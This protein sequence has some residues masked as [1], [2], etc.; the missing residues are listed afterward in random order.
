MRPRLVIIEDDPPLR[1]YLRTTLAAAGYD[2]FEAEN[3]Q[4]GL[5]EAA[6][7]R[8][9]AILLDLGLPDIDGLTVLE[10]LRDWSTAPV[11]VI[12][13]R[14]QEETKVRALD[15]GASDYVVKPFGTSELLAR[16]RAVLRNWHRDDTGEAVYESHGVRIELRTRTVEAHGAAV[17]LTPT[18]FR[19]LAE[20]VRHAG[21]VVTQRH[22]LLAIWG[23][24]HAEDAHYLRLYMAQLRR[25][26]E[27]D[28]TDPQLLLTE[29]GIGYRLVAD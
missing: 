15:S 19:L 12:S 22:L 20:L 9:D 2:V 10:R 14:D 23:P 21:Q 17:R 27:T 5:G 29:Q 8:P 11:I 16:L 7:R 18:E 25:K 3:A 13:A 6:A 28:P 24:G 26:L 4:R 1:R